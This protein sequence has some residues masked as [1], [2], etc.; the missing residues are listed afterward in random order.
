MRI[1]GTDPFENGAA[2]AFLV[3]IEALADSGTDDVERLLDAIRLPIRIGLDIE[4]DEVDDATAIAACALVSEP[5]RL[6]SALGTPPAPGLAGLESLRQDAKTVVTRIAR[7]GAL[8]DRM[9]AR[10][11]LTTWIEKMDALAARLG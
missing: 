4:R 6:R 2:L 7:R 9:R 8:R 1:F 5:E 10:L 11:E 3:E